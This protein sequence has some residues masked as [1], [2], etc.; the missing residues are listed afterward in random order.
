MRLW[1]AFLNAMST[2]DDRRIGSR[3]T[4]QLLGAAPA[5]SAY[6]EL[7]HLL[8][9]VAAPPSPG[10][11]TGLRAAVAAFEAAGQ[12]GE[13]AGE[14]VPVRHRKRRALAGSVLVKA[15]AA[16][17]VLLFG[18]VALAAG[19]GSLPDDVQRHAHDVFS[20]FGVPPPDAGTV[21]PSP[22]V[23][24]VTPTAAP[25]SGVPSRTPQPAAT[26]AA[27]LCRSWEARQKN[28]KKKPMKAESL[29]T[30]T[31]AAGGSEHI[32]T[33]CA[34][35]LA[36]DPSTAA[37][38][39]PSTAATVPSQPGNGNGNGHTRTTHTPNPHRQG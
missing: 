18:G 20:V 3:E 38:G 14:P 32:T 37:T 28:P 31:E 12:H 6:P 30:L 9:A 5:G 11:L 13:P 27:G 33:F 7:S 1:D 25:S 16:A 19:T 34:A 35:V 10:E 15:A 36:G 39:D 21:P 17:A 2:S 22:P 8:A 24:Q 26:V 23:R 4:E 29:R